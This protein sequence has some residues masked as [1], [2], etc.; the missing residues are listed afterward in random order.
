M[1]SERC[2]ITP[3]AN[4]LV[5]GDPKSVLDVGVGFG[6]YGFIARAFL[7]VWRGRM[8]KKDWKIKIDGIEFYKEFEN[9]IYTFCYDK[10]FYGNVIETLPKLGKY[11]TIIF[12]H[13]L[14][15]VEKF[16]A[17]KI[18]E[19][20]HKHANKRIIIGTPKRFFKTGY[21][22]WPAEQH[23]CHFTPAELR[24]LHFEIKTDRDL[25]ILAWKDL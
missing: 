1:L 7:D 3:V 22:N 9:P 14:E 25:G 13:V 23:R 6:T 15:H 17:I 5:Q 16:R 19:E 12:M 21:E 10:V 4:L 11:D 18:L 20:A 24:G 2:N 8:F